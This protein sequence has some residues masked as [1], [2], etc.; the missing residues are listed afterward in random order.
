MPDEHETLEELARRARIERSLH[1]A[2]AIVEGIDIT[3][4]GLRWAWNR[5]AAFL[6]AR[7]PLSRQAASQK[8]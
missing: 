3:L 7:L 8:R 2:T 6:R 5:S 4:R 1:I